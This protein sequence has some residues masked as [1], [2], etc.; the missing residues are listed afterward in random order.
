MDELLLGLAAALSFVFGWNNSSFLIGN[1]RGAG[2]LSFRAA[3]IVSITGLVLGV[4]LEGS[5]MASSLV[6]SLTPTASLSILTATLLV[7]LVLTLALTLVKLPVSFSMIVVG[8]FLGASSSSALPVNVG[9]STQVVGFWFAAPVLA[10]VI[11][12]AI[13]TST[14]R[15]VAR[16]GL[17]TVD[18]L[19]RA[20][21]VTSALAVSYTL[22]A[23]NIG[24]I[25]GTT[26]GASSGPLTP[27]TMLLIL[28]LATIAGVVI[29]GRSA[30]GG[31]IG[32]RMLSLSPQGVSACFIA[33]SL[34]VWAGT[35]LA[36]PV[37]ISQCLLG[38]MLGAAYTKQVTVLNRR[39][40]GETL[41]L[42]VVAPVA[43]FVLAYMLAAAI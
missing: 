17:L 36:L 23:N 27:S 22:G 31:T 33:S 38:G 1:L 26:G 9:R 29:L 19:N 37:S 3:L 6:G 24:L 14:T 41:S 10:A 5:K 11:T 7:S 18:S 21:A 42:W 25:Y 2:S 16:F 43:A 34:V 15:F 28:T 4:Y 20:G 13:Y 12:F 39:L 40:V 8:A 35:Q 30:L 32:D